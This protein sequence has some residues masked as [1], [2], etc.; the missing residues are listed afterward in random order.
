MPGSS[1][2]NILLVYVEIHVGEGI[3]Q[4]VRHVYSRRSSTND[5]DSHLSVR[6]DGSVTAFG[7]LRRA[8]C[9]V[10]DAVHGWGFSQCIVK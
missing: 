4:L 8:G 9:A 1:Q 3:L 10:A 5:D 6:M 2:V 7:N